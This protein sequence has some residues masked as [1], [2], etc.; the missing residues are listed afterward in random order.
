MM[1]MH[2]KKQRPP[3]TTNNVGAPVT[4]D[5]YSL[6]V[7]PAGPV[8]MQDVYLVQKLT[9]F[10]RERVPDRVYHVKGGG[11][12]GSPQLSGAAR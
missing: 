8:L 1:N 11:T 6:T 2:D 5:E 7:G 10:V 4:S 3:Q 9:H 12:F